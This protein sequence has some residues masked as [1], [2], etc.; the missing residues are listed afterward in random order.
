VSGIPRLI[1]RARDPEDLGRLVR[2][3]AVS[4]LTV[5]MGQILILLFTYGLDLNGVQANVLAVTIVAVPA[6]FLYRRWVWSADGVIS[7]WGEVMPFWAMAFLGLVV[8]TAVVAW[9]VQQWDSKLVVNVANIVGYGLVWVV[10]FLVLD[11]FMFGTE[12]PVDTREL[13]GIE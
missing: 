12:P 9:A 2:Y 10:K 4:V 8:S 13:T 3:G 11:R 5:P 7:F 6:F 1:E